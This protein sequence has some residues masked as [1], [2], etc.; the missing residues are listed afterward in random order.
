MQLISHRK[1]INFITNQMKLSYK[2]FFVVAISAIAQST[3]GQRV[4]NPNFY[5]VG[6]VKADIEIKD[7]SMSAGM[8]SVKSQENLD[9]YWHKPF[10]KAKIFFTGRSVNSDEMVID[11]LVANEVRLD[12]WNNRV[13]FNTDTD[14]KVMDVSRVVNMIMEEEPNKISQ[15]V[16]PREFDVQDTKGLFKLLAFKDGMAVLMNKV[17]SVTQPTY[18]AALDTGSKEPTIDKKDQFFFWH[19]GDIQPIN[20]KKEVADILESLGVDAKTYFKESKNKLKS[21]EDFIKL[22]YFIINQE[23]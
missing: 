8:Y 21:E 2:L 11:S 17:L 22:G 6:N 4:L 9:Y 19:D 18:V 20:S 5:G 3:Y 10:K 23:S 1:Q 12:L 14:I 13:E 15:Y 7:G 16:H